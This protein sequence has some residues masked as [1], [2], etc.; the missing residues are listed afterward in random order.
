MK[1]YTRQGDD[2]TTGLLYGGRVRKDSD[3]PIAYG[4]VDE[5]QAAIGWARA[6]AGTGSD[7]DRILIHILR[8]LWVL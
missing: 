2:G 6:Q 8:D 5:A 3:Q 4:D 7:L 1:I